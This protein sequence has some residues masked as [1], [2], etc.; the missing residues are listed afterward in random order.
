MQ[1]NLLPNILA[2]ALVACFASA[3]VAQDPD[4]LRDPTTGQIDPVPPVNPSPPVDPATT[5]PINPETTRDPLPDDAGLPRTDQ[6]HPATAGKKDA[7][8]PDYGT[9]GPQDFVTKALESGRKEV[10]AARA[11]QQRASD[12]RV[13]ELAR[14]IERDHTQLNARLQSLTTAGAGAA[15]DGSDR[16]A[17]FHPGMR[18]GDDPR[19]DKGDKGDKLE[20]LQGAAFDREYLA[21]QVRMHGK[22]IAMYQAASDDASRPDVQALAREALPTLRRHAEQ[23]KTLHDSLAAN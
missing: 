17:D 11:A 16:P 2:A 19:S 23:A 13:R 20:T 7:K 22:S 15:A 4:T 3:A 6:P 12:E 10:A 21:M 9:M 1:R 18:Q 14:T 5:P 8:D